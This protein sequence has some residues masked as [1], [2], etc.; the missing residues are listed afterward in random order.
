MCGG[1]KPSP[2]TLGPAFWPQAVWYWALSFLPWGFS[3]PSV[4]P[5]G[6]IFYPK[7]C[8][9]SQ[10]LCKN[11][12]FWIIPS[13]GRGV[14]SFSLML[15]RSRLQRKSNWEDLSCFLILEPLF[16]AT[17][18]QEL[19][20]GWLWKGGGPQIQPPYTRASG[21]PESPNVWATLPSCFLSFCFI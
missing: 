11:A 9:E 16:G 6:S 13:D 15:A 4:D 10:I 14:C 7:I 8:C 1:Q 17:L 18:P 21:E 20:G 3:L 5:E 19:A 2:Q 12:S